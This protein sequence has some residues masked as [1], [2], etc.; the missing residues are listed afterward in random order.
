MGFGLDHQEALYQAPWRERRS[1]HGQGAH[2]G[3]TVR[4]KS[5]KSV[6]SMKETCVA[7]TQRAKDRRAEDEA[8]VPPALGWQGSEDAKSYP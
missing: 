1:W 8:E 6:K 7:G 2:V 3:R 5:L 4:T